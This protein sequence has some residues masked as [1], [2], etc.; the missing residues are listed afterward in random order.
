[1]RFDAALGSVAVAGG[2]G[3]FGRLSFPARRVLRW[4]WYVLVSVAFALLIVGGC[5]PPDE[6]SDADCRADLTCWSDK[7]WTT[8]ANECDPLVVR[9]TPGRYRWDIDIGV[10]MF[11]KVAWHDE[12]AGTILYE[13]HRI[14]FK[15]ASDKWRQMRYRCVYDPDARKISLLR[16]KPFSEPPKDTCGT[17]HWYTGFMP[18]NVVAEISH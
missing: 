11:D 5:A 12:A 10:P 4:F 3:I 17:R 14:K 16:V 15:S 18:N 7:H 9:S 8:A 2:R 1:V 13:G 6:L